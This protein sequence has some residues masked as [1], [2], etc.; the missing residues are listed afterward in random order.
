MYNKLLINIGSHLFHLNLNNLNLFMKL[1]G[2][3]INKE[4]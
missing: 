4:N 2:K 1:F 3:Y